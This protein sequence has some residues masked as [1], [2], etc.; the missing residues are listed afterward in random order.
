MTHS[1]IKTGLIGFGLSGRIFHAPFILDHPDFQLTAVNS[2]QAEAVAELAPEARVVASAEALLA[3]DDLDLI[4][5]TAP[6]ALH[7]PL[8]EAALLAG[9]HVLLEK[10][11]VTELAQ[12]ETLATLAQRQGKVLTV[13]QNRRFDGDFQTLRELVSNGSLGSLKHLDTRFDRFRPTPQQRWRE[14]PGVGTGIFWDLGPHILDQVLHLLG[15]PQR[16]HATLRTL[17]DGGTTTDWFEVQLDYGDKVVHLGST[18]FEAGPMRRFAARFEGGSW[19]AWG[20]DPQ[21]AALRAGQMPWHPDY[22]SQGAAQTADLSDA[23]GT[24][25]QALASGHY[26]A[27]YHQLADAILGRGPAPVSLTE[28]CQLVYGL[29]LAEQSS[30]EGRWLDWQYQPTF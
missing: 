3:D 4:V 22:P 25:S 11:S 19:H 28:A 27:F 20:L 8:A 29:Q 10:P 17:R 30:A 2:R 6:N 21:E 23:Q 9:K 26:R 16:L 15:T 24:Q 12:M 7:F 5:I 13:Y 14:Q 1:T 18:P